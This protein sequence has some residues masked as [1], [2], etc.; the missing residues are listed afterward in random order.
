MRDFFDKVPAIVILFILVSVVRGI[1]ALFKGKK[2]EAPPAMDGGE[3][4][5]ERRVREIQERIR[6][7]AAE[8]RGQAQP[9]P[10]P[11]SFAPPVVTPRRMEP[12]PLSTPTAPPLGSPLQRKLL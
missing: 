11:Q 4:D 3:R 9:A 8:R 6:R 7:I 2:S 5:E 10:P 1:T 12:P